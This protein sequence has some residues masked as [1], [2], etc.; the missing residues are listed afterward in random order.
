MWGRNLFFPCILCMIATMAFLTPERQNEI[1]QTVESLKLRTGLSYPQNNLL[2]FAKELQA[3]VFFTDLPKTDADTEI[4]GVIK[5]ENG[6]AKILLNSSYSPTRKTF[7]LAHELGHF[8][9]HPN[10]EK[11]RIDSFN[12]KDN[13]VESLEETEANYF[14]ATLLMPKD[15]FIK[16][17]STTGDIG[18]AA[19]YFGVSEIAVK[20]RLKWL[21]RK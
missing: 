5:W 11:L 10:Q 17:I 20:N 3:E 13:T 6:G 9:L 12:Y 7:T 16:V 1:D 18:A 14:A 21:A 8:L 4:D 15:Q 2:D 19:Q